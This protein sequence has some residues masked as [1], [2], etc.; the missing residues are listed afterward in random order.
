MP[1][2]LERAW[3]SLHLPRNDDE[4]LLAAA[5]PVGAGK[6]R[7][8]FLGPNFEMQRRGGADF[9]FE[10]PAAGIEAEESRS[11]RRREHG[12]IRIFGRIGLPA[13]KSSV[14]E[15][16]QRYVLGPGFGAELAEPRAAIAYQVDNI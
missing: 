11:E 1:M 12:C 4:A 10:P 9:K 3:R 15:V 16:V 7:S 5:N 8:T 13:Q 2:D 6:K 14:R